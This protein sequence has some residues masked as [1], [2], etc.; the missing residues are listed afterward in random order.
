MQ[1]ITRMVKVNNPTAVLLNEDGVFEVTSPLGSVF[2]VCC[3]R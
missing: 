3:L 2:D 1:T